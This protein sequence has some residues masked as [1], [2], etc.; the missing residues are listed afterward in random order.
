MGELAFVMAHKVN[1]VSALHSDL[2]KKSVFSRLHAAFPDRIINQTNGVTPRRWLYSC[3]PALRGLLNDTIGDGW[4]DDLERLKELEAHIED[5]AFLDA[6]WAAKHANKIRLAEWLQDRDGVTVNPDAMFDIQV[7]R[8]HEYKR[9]LLN[10]L[11]TVAL[12]NDIRE[13]P[14][15]DWT[16]RVKIFGGKAAPGY[17][18]AKDIVRLINDVGARINSDPATRDLLQVVYPENYNV[19]VAEVLIPAADLSE[20]ISTAGKEASGTGNMKL[21]LNGALTIGTLDGANVEIRD[22]VGPENFFLFGLTAEEVEE[23]RKIPGYPRKTIEKSPRLM[24]VLAQ[25]AEGVFSDG[26]KERYA[27]ILTNVWEHDYFL[28]SCDFEAYYASQRDV[29][30]AYRDRAGWSH[31]AALNTARLGWFSSD[32]T[33]QGYANDIWNVRSLVK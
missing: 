4:V 5:P 13:N 6:F 31:K 8:I 30:A 12:W 29:D 23:R 19:S 15:A 24:K 7:K 18:L 28:V 3:N 20:Q 11:E 33:I 14:N 25:I 32:R 22:H 16:P 2:V 17:A 1:G 26:D 9:Q 27:S 21:G 10:I